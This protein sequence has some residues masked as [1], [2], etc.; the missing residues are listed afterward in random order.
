MSAPVPTYAT[1]KQVCAEFVDQ[2]RASGDW[3]T[4]IWLHERP[5]RV[6]ALQDIAFNLR[7]REYWEMVSHV[8]SDSENI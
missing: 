8:W 7:G 6:E 5:Y 4:Y 3:C 1:V 2:A